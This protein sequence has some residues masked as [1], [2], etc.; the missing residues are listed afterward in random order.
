[1]GEGVFKIGM[2]R[3]LEPLERVKELGDAAVPFPF[4]VHAMIFTEQRANLCELLAAE[5][6][7]FDGHATTLV[8]GQQDSLVADVL[9]QT[10]NCVSRQ[11]M[12]CCC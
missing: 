1:M 6:L 9:H 8:I 5:N 11:S 3:R 2:T 12:R 7:S 10:A 4:D